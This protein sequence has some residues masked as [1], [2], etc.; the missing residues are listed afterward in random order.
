M[1][2]C[3]S[4]MSYIDY[5]KEKLLKPLGVNIDKVGVRLSD[6]ANIEDLVKH[7]T[8]VVNRSYI[9][10]WNKQ[11]RQLNIIQIPNDL[12]TWLYISF[13]GFSVHPAGLL[14][15]SAGTLSIYLH[16]FLSNGSSIL[17]PQ[18]IAE[19]RKVVG[20]GLIPYYN[21]QPSNNSTGQSSQ[22][23]FGLS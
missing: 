20:N 11:I 3:V 16:M 7:Y 6:F 4:N 15:M 2:T 5:V 23:Q 18:S 13:F 17:R 12:P 22:V 19:M 8:Y 21:P 9:L 10:D 14:R 1:R